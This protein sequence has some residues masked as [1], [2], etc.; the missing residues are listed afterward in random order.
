ML[1]HY[2]QSL[3]RI[4]YIFSNDWSWW[5]LNGYTS[6]KIYLRSLHSLNYVSVGF[7]QAFRVE[8]EGIIPSEFVNLEFK[9]HMHKLHALH[10]LHVSFICTTNRIQGLI[11]WI[12]ASI[13]AQSRTEQINDSKHVPLLPHRQTDRQTD[14]RQ[15]QAQA[16][17]QAHA[18]TQAQAQAQAHLH[19]VTWTVSSTTSF[20]RQHLHLATN[21]VT[22]LMANTLVKCFMATPLLI[23]SF[24]FCFCLIDVD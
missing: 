12:A 2:D 15:A 16:Q 8:N 3:Q 11:I 6:E 17:A 24:G 22:S 7:W 23:Y 18:Q 1:L 21:Y 5:A 13:H 9:Q 10:A 20:I 19:T 4:F 14:R